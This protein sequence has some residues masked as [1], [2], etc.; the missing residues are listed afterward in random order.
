M[1]LQDKRRFI[2]YI[3]QLT[4]TTEVMTKN[5]L[6]NNRNYRICLNM[7]IDATNS[8]ILAS[9]YFARLLDSKLSTH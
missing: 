2:Y 6:N 7:S 1:S 4:S 3:E 9:Y 5:I 8:D